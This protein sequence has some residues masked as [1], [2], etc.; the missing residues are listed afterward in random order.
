MKKNKIYLQF[1]MT[2]KMK[3][4]LGEKMG[5]QAIEQMKAQGK[6]DVKL[7]QK[8]LDDAIKNVVA[9]DVENKYIQIYLKLKY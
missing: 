2:E 8:I 4:I 3:K 9:Q 7:H 5:S 1:I 6:I